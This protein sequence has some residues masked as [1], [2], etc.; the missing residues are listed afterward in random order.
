[1]NKTALR[2]PCMY[3]VVTIPVYYKILEVINCVVNYL[4]LYIGHI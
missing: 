2:V 3:L 1:M 4:A